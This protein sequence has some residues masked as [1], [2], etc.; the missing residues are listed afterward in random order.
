MRRRALPSLARYTSTRRSSSLS[1]LRPHTLTPAQI[2][3]DSRR[4]G[5]G[6]ASF[7]GDAN[8]PASLAGGALIIANQRERSI[9]ALEMQVPDARYSCPV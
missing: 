8:P 2:L 1:G 5:E 6:W 3:L 7:A 9:P 4:G